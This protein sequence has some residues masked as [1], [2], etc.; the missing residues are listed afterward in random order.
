M[1]YDSSDKSYVP[2]VPRRTGLSRRVLLGAAAGVGL[3]ALNRLLVD[4]AGVGGALGAGGAD[5]GTPGRPDAAPGAAGARHAP[6][7]VLAGSGRRLALTFDDGPHPTWTPQIL[8]LLRQHGVPATFFVL[9][10]NAVW[11]PDLL[12]AIAADGHL[13]ANHSYDHPRFDRLPRDEVRA[14]LGRT[15]EVIENA[16]G[17]PPGW[18]RAPYGLWT[19]VSLEICGELA[20][21]PLDWS[22]D[23]DDWRRPGS[24]K[25]A[26]NLMRRAHPGGIV[27]AHD[28]GGDR[29]QTVTALRDCLPRLRE[30]GYELV[31][32][33]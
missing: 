16:L 24:A 25:I 29:A 9:G 22:V 33:A 26:D 19:A 21:K 7:R 28:G 10:E 23:T 13:V 4:S 2:S 31:R 15:S 5:T 6:G 11:Q 1:S 30:R 32:P 14:Q 18:A 3:L 27:L 17:A 20:M 8:G 12:R